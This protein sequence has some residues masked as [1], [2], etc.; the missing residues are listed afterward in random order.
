MTTWTS[1][2][3]IA[4]TGETREFYCL[5]RATEHAR[6]VRGTVNGRAV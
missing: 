6:K 1:Y 3:V 2:T 4:A 5:I